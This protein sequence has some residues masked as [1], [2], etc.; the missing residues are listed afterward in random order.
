MN[1]PI[2]P[3]DFAALE[4]AAMRRVLI[5]STSKNAPQKNVKDRLAPYIGKGMTQQQV[6]D[7]LGCSDAAVRF[8]LR[9][10]GAKL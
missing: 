2:T 7:I 9:K 3:A 10:M 8:A 1:K 5:D 4:N 6:A